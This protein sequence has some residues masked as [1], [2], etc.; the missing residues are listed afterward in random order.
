MT[1]NFTARAGDTISVYVTV[2]DQDGQP[3]NLTGASAIWQAAP[4]TPRRF[5]S[6]PVLTKATGSGIT[7]TNAA[8]G[9]LRID[10]QPGDTAGLV[11]DFYHELQTTDSGGASTTPLA[12][13]MTLTP[14]LVGAV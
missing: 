12:G 3:V 7:I 13:L 6:T 8:A 5:A 14:Q 10:L 4:G 9:E 2:P 11:G 1:M